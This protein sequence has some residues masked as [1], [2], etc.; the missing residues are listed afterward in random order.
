MIDM[1]ILIVTAVL[2]LIVLVGFFATRAQ[3]K[4]SKDPVST[5]EDDTENDS[6]KVCIPFLPFLPCARIMFFTNICSNTYF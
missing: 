6:K 2:G 3:Q 1:Q 4:G 5:V